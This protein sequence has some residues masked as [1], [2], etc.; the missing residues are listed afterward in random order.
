MHQVI[1]VSEAHAGLSSEAVFRIIEQSARNNPSADITGFLIFAEG[2]FLQLIEGPLQALETL[3]ATLRRDPRHHS[4]Q[5]LARRPIFERSFPRWR[6]KRVGDGQDALGE[7]RAVLA[8]EGRGAVLP[9][10]VTAFVEAQVA[11]PL[12]PAGA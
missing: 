8:A 4:L 1:Y 9:P 3:I 11:R 5:I 2:R 12:S 10:E 7:L 6:M